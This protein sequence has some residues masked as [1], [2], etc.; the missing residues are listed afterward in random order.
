MD[1]DVHH[2]QGTQYAFYDDARV[3]YMSIHRYEHA[4]F[5][6]FLRQSDHDF[7]GAST[8]AAPSAPGKTASARGYN[9]NVPLNQVCSVSVLLHHVRRKSKFT[10]I[11]LLPFTCSP[12]LL[13]SLSTCTL[14]SFFIH[15][16]TC[17]INFA[18]FNSLLHVNLDTSRV[19]TY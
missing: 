13:A 6:P 7:I 3:L 14:Y 19:Y 12:F 11:S 1:W 4:S 17:T 9:I 18:I 10:S 5:W 15:T 2:G 8:A 16:S